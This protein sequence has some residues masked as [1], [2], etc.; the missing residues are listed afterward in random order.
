MFHS[1]GRTGIRLFLFCAALAVKHPLP[2]VLAQPPENIKD[3][4]IVDCL[5]D[6]NST[7][8]AR[9]PVLVSATHEAYAEVRATWRNISGEAFC[10]VTARLFVSVRRDAGAHAFK[11]VFEQP[12]TTERMGNGLRVVDWSPDGRQ[13]AFE[14]FWWQ[15]NSDVGGRRA[16]VYDVDRGAAREIHLQ[17]IFRSTLGRSCD[18]RLDGIRGFTPNGELV[19]DVRDYVD[20]YDESFRPTACFRKNTRWAIDKSARRARPLPS[21][22][23]VQQFSKQLP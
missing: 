2:P 10:A 20:A 4:S 16:M 1:S 18:V 8:T 22:Y 17:E 13:L 12:P 5:E 23:A 14:A 11:P 9:S 7:R 3:T 21:D 19:V 6:R 15:P